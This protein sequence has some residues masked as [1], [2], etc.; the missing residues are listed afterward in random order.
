MRIRTAV[1][2]VLQ[3]TVPAVHAQ[4]PQAGSTFRDCLDCPE[5]IVVA[6]GEYRMGYGRK[7]GHGGAAPAPESP[8]HSVKIGY[9]FAVGRFEVTRRQFAE[10]L[11]A[12][13]HT[14]SPNNCYWLNLKNFRWTSDDDSLNWKTPGFTQGDDH[15][16][17]CVTWHDAKAYAGWLSRR[18]GKS[19]RLLSEA[20]WE[21]VAR[22][23]ADGQIPWSEGEI[24]TC[25]HANVWDETIRKNFTLRPPSLSYGIVASK[26]GPRIRD[27]V[28]NPLERWR[29]EGWQFET[30]SCN[31][32]QIY[33]ASVGSYAANP[34]GL[35][36]MIGNVW[37]W[38]E[39]CYNASYE[40]A[41]ADGSAWDSGNC[42]MRPYRGGS[43][44]TV[45]NDARVVRRMHRPAAS[46]SGDLGFRVARSL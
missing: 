30:H 1:L 29:Q 43:W 11:S 17:V 23:G 31:D 12:S 6:P 39:D 21:Y 5:M 33:T 8:R 24:D 3:L 36:D 41:P 25:R 18:T 22:A 13:G 44:S 42:D 4:A 27:S 7:G 2:V 15:P 16:A 9:A 28:M 46:R 20:E 32:G 26:S 38:V 10:F 35:H 37:E 19:Y 45:P 40:D 34:F 14:V